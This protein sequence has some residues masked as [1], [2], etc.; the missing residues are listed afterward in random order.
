MPVTLEQ[1]L[2]VLSA[3]EP[4][5]ASAARLGVNALPHLQ[6][7]ANG[8]DV[9]LAAKAVHLASLIGGNIS[10]DVIADAAQ[11]TN[12][13]LRIVAAASL[14]S[15]AADRFAD[16]A[17]RL[18]SDQDRAVRQR[19]LNSLPEAIS[20]DLRDRLEQLADALPE[21]PHRSEVVKVI[22]RSPYAS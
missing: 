20:Q 18:I 4:D 22:K 11:H 15:I 14:N 19:A 21:G 2:R 10:S 7:L 13:I 16:T 9:G 1:V 12:P 8:P 3:D 6:V 17:V 5:Y